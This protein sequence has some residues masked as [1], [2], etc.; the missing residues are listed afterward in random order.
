[1]TDWFRRCRESQKA[2]YEYG[3]KLE[4]RHFWFGIPAIILSTAVGAS[5]FKDGVDAQIR[6]GLGLLSMASAVVAALQTFLNLS[7]RA[8]KHKASGASY[9]AIRRALEL[10]KTLPPADGDKMRQALE[11]IKGRM[12]DLA[13]SAP[14][15]PSKF[16]DK[17]DKGL[18]G[19]IHN[20]IFRLIPRAVESELN[21]NGDSP[22]K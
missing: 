6:L 14:A 20:R 10:L 5:F 3:S 11:D 9:G 21:S 17:I 7:D 4:S 22:D 16:K 15:I 13:A 19:R 1:M 12:D 8:A 18:K 2:H